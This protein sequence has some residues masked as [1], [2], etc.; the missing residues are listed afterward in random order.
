[1]NPSNLDVHDLPFSV[2]TATFSDLLDD[3]YQA[4]PENEEEDTHQPNQTGNRPRSK[5]EEKA[6][7]YRCYNSDNAPIM[8][9]I[10]T[11]D[12]QGA[13]DVASLIHLDC[14]QRPTTTMQQIVNEFFMRTS[15]LKLD[16]GTTVDQ[17]Y[18][19]NSAGQPSN[20]PTNP[21]GTPVL[22]HPTNPPTHLRVHYSTARPTWTQT[23]ANGW[24]NTLNWGCEFTGYRHW[25]KPV[26]YTYGIDA[27]E[28]LFV[29]IETPQEHLA[30]ASQLVWPR[31]SMEWTC[32]KCTLLN[33]MNMESCVV[34]NQGTIPVETSGMLQRARSDQEQVANQNGERQELRSSLLAWI[35]GEGGNQ[36]FKFHKLSMHWSIYAFAPLP[37]TAEDMVRR[38]EWERVERAK[39]SERNNPTNKTPDRQVQ[40]RRDF[41]HGSNDSILGSRRRRTSPRGETIPRSSFTSPFGR[42]PPSPTSF[43]DILLRSTSMNS[44]SSTTSTSSL[45]TYIQAGPP[46]IFSG[47]MNFDGFNDFGGMSDFPTGLSVP[48]SS[49]VDNFVTLPDDA[50]RN[51]NLDCFRDDEAAHFSSPDEEGTENNENANTRPNSPSSPRQPL[52]DSASADPDDPDDPDGNNDRTDHEGSNG[53]DTNAEGEAPVPSVPEVRDPQAEMLMGMACKSYRTCVQLLKQCNGDIGQAATKILD[54]G[55][56][57][58]YPE[59]DGKEPEE[60]KE[61][62]QEVKKDVVLEQLQHVKA[63]LP[64]V[65]LSEAVKALKALVLRLRPKNKNDLEQ[66]KKEWEEKVNK[67]KKKGKTIDDDYG[68]SSTLAPRR[69]RGVQEGKQEGKLEG[70]LEGELEEKELVTTF[71]AVNP[72]APSTGTTK[73]PAPPAPMNVPT[74][75]VEY[76][77]VRDCVGRIA[78]DMVGN[79][80]PSHESAITAKAVLSWC[81]KLCV[82]L[83]DDQCDASCLDTLLMLLKNTDHKLYKGGGHTPYGVNHYHLING[84]EDLF[85]Q[86]VDKDDGM[87]V[88]LDLACAGEGSLEI[89]E[90]KTLTV[91]VVDTT[92]VGTMALHSDDLEALEHLA[93][94]LTDDGAA[95]SHAIAALNGSKELAVVLNRSS[96]TQEE[97]KEQEGEAKA[98]GQGEKEGGCWNVVDVVRMKQHQQI[99][100]KLIQKVQETIDDYH[101]SQITNRFVDRNPKWIGKY[102]CPCPSL[103][104]MLASIDTY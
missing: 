67:A 88:Y 56:V 66:E 87:N 51:L 14:I 71:P 63:T 24:V 20:P 97:R 33:S 80:Y 6:Y 98:K 2:P 77:F 54:P 16:N 7:H 31:D 41:S 47:D 35:T 17:D 43:G 27:C 100:Q 45:S 83:A 34:C 101:M 39:I 5:Q 19:F 61:D 21:R 37:I 68:A 1:M 13:V 42:S 15:E 95:V 40:K 55:F 53:N 85:R 3:G 91:R 30:D 74:F 4:Q 76:S 99:Q 70:E 60:Q 36:A 23:S 59:T 22:T 64:K 10:C 102:C 8:C 75:E 18:S 69:Q 94:S 12:A 84:R 28:V 92:V 46:D 96:D 49:A 44:N 57:D 32:D 103:V 78:K 38:E 90:Q 72:A 48:S 73:P 25:D 26:H 58:P 65:V 29:L 81:I 86:F 9:Y 52:L 93:F 89:E 11:T 62:K 50:L 104:S 79:N 82:I